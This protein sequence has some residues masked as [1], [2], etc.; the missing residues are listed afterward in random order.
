MSA[1]GC[2]WSAYRRWTS[3]G[4]QK[5]VGMWGTTSTSVSP[6][7]TSSTPTLL[8]PSLIW[9]GPCSTPCHNGGRGVISRI[10]STAFLAASGQQCP[11]PRRC[12]A[13]F[14]A[15]ESFTPSPVTATMAPAGPVS[16]GVGGWS[17]TGQPRTEASHLPAA[18]SECFQSLAALHNHQ[19][20]LRDWCESKH[21]L[22]VESM[23]PR[24]L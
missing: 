1:Q 21:H 10:I 8:A 22:W 15:G 11:W 18:S 23:V 12:L 24:Q 3:S 20:L 16:T 9:P 13:F 5:S 14:R 6:K 17:V 2:S 4:C 19:L 7:P